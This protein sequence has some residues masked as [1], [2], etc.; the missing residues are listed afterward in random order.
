MS[1]ETPQ[2]SP[3]RAAIDEIEGEFQ[4]LEPAN[5][6]AAIVG[7][8]S[9]F[10]DDCG[11]ICYDRD[12]VIE[13]LTAGGMSREEANGFFANILGAD[14]D[15]EMPKLITSPKALMATHNAPTIR[16]AINNID[17][18]FLL[19]EPADMDSAIA[20]LV[21]A[22]GKDCGVVCYDRDQVIELLMKD[23]M[24]RDEAEEFFSFNI[25]GAYM[26]EATPVYLTSAKALIEQADLVN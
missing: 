16:A 8:V 4:L 1:Q 26:G 12:A 20:G 2:V 6:D 11:V 14:V 10:G 18:E 7:L 17:G 23:G 19:L 5:L 15:A 24:D 13:I 3:I 21:S 9:A 25:E 22:R